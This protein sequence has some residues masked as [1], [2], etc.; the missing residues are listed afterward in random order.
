[1]EEKPLISIVLATYNPNLGWLQ[2]QLRSLDAQT[3]PKLNLFLRDDCSDR[4]PFSEIRNCAEECVHAFPVTLLRNQENLG[5]TKT[6][7]LLTQEADGAFLAYCDQD[8]VWLPE[9][10][11]RLYDA[12]KESRAAL[13]CSDM[14]V[15]D[16]SGKT[17]ADSITQVRRHHRFLSG[18]GLAPGLLFRNWVTGCTMLVSAACAKAAVPFCPYMVHDHYLALFCALRGPILSLREPLIRYRIHGG[19][20]TSILAGVVDRESYVRIRIVSL[21][22]RLE[23][24]QENLDCSDRFR[25]QIARGLAW[26]NARRS[27]L[28]GKGGGAAV[29]K[30]RRLGLLPS[31]FELTAARL[32]EPFF[33][34]V[35][36]LV[37][38]NKL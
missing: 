26:A 7:E 19:N 10:I 8:D 11:G 1:M 12:V 33:R 21:I 38:G 22:D 5:S 18:E 36:G 25:E 31:L 29:W 34:K 6:F 30:L 13:A 35:I 23:W 2:E 27:N 16:A 20:Q 24:L 14:Y 9:K 15:M 32:P 37:R 3:Y 28:E 4:V 17:V